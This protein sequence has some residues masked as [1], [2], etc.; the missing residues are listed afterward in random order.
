MPP[1][2]QSKFENYYKWSKLDNNLTTDG[3][4]LFCQVCSKSVSLNDIGDHYIW[5][6]V[7]ET[8]DCRGRYI[9]NFV[10]GKL[11]EQEPGKAYLLASKEIPQTNHKTVANFFDDCLRTFLSMID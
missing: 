7:D 2:K 9:A 6:S 4:N 5:T 1:N 10:V 11:S 8:T 3:E